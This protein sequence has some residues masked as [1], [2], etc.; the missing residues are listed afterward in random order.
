LG[1]ERES[2]GERVGP[3]P[4]DRK[5]GERKGEGREGGDVEAGRMLAKGGRVRRAGTD[6]GAR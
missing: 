3:S 5:R 6:R 1:K 4:I 2:E